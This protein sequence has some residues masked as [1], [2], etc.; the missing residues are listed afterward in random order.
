MEMKLTHSERL[1]LCHTLAKFPDDASYDDIHTMIY[2][3]D[4]LNDE[5]PAIVPWTPY[6]NMTGADLIQAQDDLVWA[7]DALIVNILNDDVMRPLD[8]LARGEDR[9]YSI[10]YS[11][12]AKHTQFTPDDARLIEDA[13]AAY[14]K[15]AQ[16]RNSIKINMELY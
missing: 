2:S 4:Y 12:N 6:E 10:Q 15:L 1:A 13:T 16:I 11:P 8:R 3:G 9:L 14:R 7:L 5:N